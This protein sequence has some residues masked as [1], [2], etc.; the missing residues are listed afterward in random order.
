MIRMVFSLLILAFAVNPAVAAS[1][2]KDAGSKACWQRVYTNAELKKHRRQKVAMVQ[3]AVETQGDG[4]VS[5]W[6]GINL[7]KRTGTSKYDYAIGGYCKQNGQT[8]KCV[9]EWD[10]GTFILEK[11]ARDGLRVKNRKLIVNPSNYDSEDISD[12]AIN[13]RKSDDAIWLLFPADPAVCAVR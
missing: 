1:K 3:L 4:T 7:R 8:L 10:A 12:K 13:F 6:L 11:G 9:P 5:A 2:P